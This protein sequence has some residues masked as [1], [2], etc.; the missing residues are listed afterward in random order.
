MLVALA[1]PSPVYFGPAITTDLANYYGDSD[2]SDP[3]GVFQ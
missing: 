2:G 3:K 1:Q